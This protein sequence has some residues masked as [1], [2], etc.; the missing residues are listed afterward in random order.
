MGEIEARATPETIAL[1]APDVRGQADVAQGE[2]GRQEA[3]RTVTYLMLVRTALATVL[4]MS[5]VI[6][7]LTLGSPETLSGPFGR[8]VF[9][10]LAT[11]YVA[12]LAYALGLGRI[13]D[14]VRF[15][16]IQ[17]GVDLVLVTLLIH[18]TGGAQSGYT[19]L[20]L[21]DVVAVSLLPK[22]FSPGNVAAASALLFVG[23]SL[24]GYLRIL[25]PIT[26]QTVFPWDLT[27]EELVF[28]LVVYLAGVVS[29]AALGMSLYAK[30]REA[31]ER[32][33]QH[34]RIAG[35][36][37]SLH[38]NT[39]RCLSAGLVTTTL[40]G[41]MTSINDAAC[42]IL[43]IGTPAP[44]GQRLERLIP[45]MAI[46][47]AEDLLLGRVIRQ[48]VEAVHANG[49]PR[50]LAVSATPL[51]DH[52]GR[53]V[54][55][56]IHFQ[57]L[58]ELRSMEGAVRRSERLAGIGRLAANIAH[59]IRNPLA[60]ISGSVE[61]LR[62]QPGTD[63]EARQL[64]DIAVREVDRVNGLISGLL[65]YARPRTE[66][67]QRLDLGEMVNE[68]AKVFEQERRSVEVRVVVDA[69]PGVAVE[70]ASGQ[71][72]QVLWNLLRNAVT[73][74]PGG[75][76][77]RLAVSRR[78][79]TNGV[80]EAV[81]SVS[82]TGI[83]IPHED[84]DHIFEPFFSRRADGTGLGL[85]ITARIVEDHKGSIEVS[86]EVGKGTTFVIRFPAAT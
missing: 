67:R 15:A 37:A 54:G 45:G 40:D 61:V 23:I 29:V 34:E 11:T 78:D 24:L 12:T 63:A 51:S 14:P 21:V 55:R 38:Q 73:A 72:R 35:D 86:S 31:R 52:T 19:F 42:E 56:V 68:I 20:Y 85:A 65:D 41:T 50:C 58:T 22:R 83:G 9:A 64:I 47:M 59:E 66:D 77:V 80:S 13:Q 2:Q 71:L 32:L 10:L 16:D 36:L 70:G 3:L 39:I 6:L 25:P 7:A 74:M 75:G 27:L 17:I 8:F 69:E 84:L 79:R 4:M 26:G 62:K 76:R 60:S 28:R 46:V 1:G 33:A 82:D 5:V 53:I 43:G 30:T 44:V 18:A 49:S 48:E 81:L 57:D